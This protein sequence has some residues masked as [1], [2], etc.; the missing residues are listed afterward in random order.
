MCILPG[1]LYELAKM[2]GALILNETGSKILIAN[3]QF[4]IQ[5]EDFSLNAPKFNPILGKA[6]I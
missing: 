3:A 4:S 2:D 1:S 6:P 5:E